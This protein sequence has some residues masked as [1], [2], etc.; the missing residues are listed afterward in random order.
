MTA[1]RMGAADANTTP[2]RRVAY[3][4]AVALL[5]II[6]SVRVASTHRTFSVVVDEPAHL[7]A[8]YDWWQGRYDVDASHPPLARILFALPFARAADPGTRHLVD[9]GNELLY[10][11]E[12]YRR[13]IAAGRAGNLVALIA[14]TLA[15]AALARRLFS[16]SVA[17]TATA[18]YTALPPIL[19]HAG[20]MTTDM[21]A[22]AAIA[23]ALWAFDR[24]L[25]QPD[26]SRT[27]VLGLALGGGLLSKFSFLVF[28][29]A[30]VA[31]W[32]LAR[33]TLPSHRVRAALAIACVVVWAGYRFDVATPAE[34]S[35]QGAVLWEVAAPGRLAPAARWAAENLVLPAPQFFNGVA[36]LR[37]HDATGHYAFL[38]GEVRDSGWWYYFPVVFFYKTPLP[39]LLLCGLGLLVAIRLRDRAALALCGVAMAIMAVAMTSA[40]N[41]GVRHVLPLYAPLAIVAAFAAARI[42]TSARDAYGR[43]IVAAIGLWFF[44]GPALAHPDY[45]A[46]FNEA[47]GRT[48]AV[49]AVDS[50][51]DWGQDTLRL[52]RYIR[53]HALER[54]HVDILSSARLAEHGIEPD[55]FDPGKRTPGW[56]AISETQLALR[57]SAGAYDWLRIYKPVARVGRSIRIYSIPE[58]AAS[59]N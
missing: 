9:L 32:L 22:A 13:A 48:P 36:L 33:R 23:V 20:L 57:G 28:F 59:V 49:V 24:F 42:W 14:A 3:W 40:I 31:V 5:V 10:R 35:A 16:T 25:E 7:G 44:A 39:F 4:A 41:I 50:N 15:T 52:A 54:V 30:A 45:L 38:L 26:W 58:C 55:P 17:I 11:A 6:A 53:E 27:I 34:R 46:W 21:I 47:A 18:I 8:G 29:P 56:L 43:A 12:S 51:I 1:T 2:D 19:G 37:I